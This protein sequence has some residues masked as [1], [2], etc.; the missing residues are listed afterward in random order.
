MYRRAHG[1]Q[2]ARWVHAA[3]HAHPIRV[4]VH[5]RMWLTMKQYVH[6]AVLKTLPQMVAVPTLSHATYE[7]TLISDSALAVWIQGIRD[8]NSAV[9]LPELIRQREQLTTCYAKLVRAT[10]I[11]LMSQL[12]D[13]RNFSV[14]H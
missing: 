1:R 14:N 7:Y 4:L 12:F 6:R 2:C 10:T 3:V 5:R 9:T 8:Q 11:E 13:R